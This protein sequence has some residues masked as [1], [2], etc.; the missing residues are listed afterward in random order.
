MVWVFGTWLC[1]ATI[2]VHMMTF[3][4]LIAWRWAPITDWQNMMIIS[5]CVLEPG[6]AKMLLTPRRFGSG[7]CG[8][9]LAMAS[10]AVVGLA[11]PGLL[12]SRCNCGGLLL[13][14]CACSL[15][16][17][18]LNSWI[19]YAHWM[20][21]LVSICMLS[22]DHLGLLWLISIWSYEWTHTSTRWTFFCV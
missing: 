19:F 9:V 1:F 12:L 22:V 21:V 18:A 20:L 7:R 15:D 11:S 6:E 16:S 3:L 4:F 8:A 2:Y 10:C 13:S 17:K 14:P 5:T